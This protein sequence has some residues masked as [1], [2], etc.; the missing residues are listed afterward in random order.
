MASQA[1][2]ASGP[3]PRGGS[4]YRERNSTADRTL[5][6]LGMF[7]EQT[8]RISAQQ[9]ADSLGVARS[10]AYRYLQTLSAENYI[11]EDPDSGFRLGV[12][13]FGLA[14][15]ARRSY[16]LSTVAV[17]ILRELADGTGETALLTRRAGNQVICLEKEESTQ[18][19]LRL[20]YDRGSLLSIN[21]GASALVLLAWENQVTIDTLLRDAPLP[22]FTASTVTDPQAIVRQLGVIRELGYAVTRGQLDSDAVG[23]AAPVRDEYH[24][25]VA[26][27]SVVAVGRRFPEDRVAELVA[28]VTAAAL[29]LAAQFALISQ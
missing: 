22:S 6:I 4:G 21:A 26:G 8:L 16:G 19:W 13:V 27:L 20:S 23:V 10:T 14:R 2:A 28:L 7:N 29:R 17:P 25:V 3:P 5:D 9:V 15:L 1:L 11:E 18:H 12:K 24:R